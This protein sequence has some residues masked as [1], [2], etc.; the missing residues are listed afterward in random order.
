MINKIFYDAHCHIFN[1]GY[2]FKEAKCMIAGTCRYSYK[3]LEEDKGFLIL[4]VKLQ[5][6]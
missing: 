1:L 3:T 2:A 6:F 4:L 5:I